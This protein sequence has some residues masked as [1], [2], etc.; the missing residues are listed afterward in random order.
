MALIRRVCACAERG[1]ASLP[2]TTKTKSKQN[3]RKSKEK[4]AS[5]LAKTRQSKLFIYHSQAAALGVYKYKF[6]SDFC[7]YCGQEKRGRAEEKCLQLGK[8]NWKSNWKLQ[9][10][11]TM[12][13]LY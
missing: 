7:E 8:L 1:H 2:D 13:I 4:E 12:Y 10:I 6:A 3:K 9:I 11:A 5:R